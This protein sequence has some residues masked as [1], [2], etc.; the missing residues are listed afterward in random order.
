MTNVD[1][2]C[3]TVQKDPLDGFARFALADALEEEGDERA[4]KERMI[5]ERILKGTYFKAEK[6]K[7]LTQIRKAFAYKK[8]D[9]YI[10]LATECPLH[11]TFWDEGSRAYYSQ[12]DLTSEVIIYFGGSNPFQQKI[13]PIEKVR[14]GTIIVCTGISCGKTATMQIFVRPDD[15]HLFLK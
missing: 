15:Y 2:L 10:S 5:G 13:T 8:R 12:Y 3:E 6:G 4:G 14:P 1:I 7:L 9:V 11:G